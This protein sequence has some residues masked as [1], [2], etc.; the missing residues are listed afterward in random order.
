LKHHLGQLWLTIP[1]RELVAQFPAKQTNVGRKGWFDVAGGIGLQILKPYYKCSD[2]KLIDLLNENKKMQY[3]CGIDLKPGEYIRD[4]GVV[5]RWRGYLGRHLKEDVLQ[6]ILVGAWKPHMEQTHVNLSDAT[7]YESHVRYPTDVKLLWESIEWLWAQIRSIGK[8][9]KMPLPRVK[10][11][12]QK[13]KYQSYQRRRRKFKKEERRTRRRLLY[14]LDKLLGIIPVFIGGWKRSPHLV[15]NPVKRNFFQRLRTIK[16]VSQQQK[17]HF[18]RPKDSIPNRIVSLAKPYIRP[19]VRGKETKRVEFGM[20][21]HK[22]QIDG[23][24]FIEHW[25]FE[26]FHEGVRLKKTV[27]KHHRY[28]GKCHQFAGD[29][30]YA[31]NKNRKYCTSS[32]I[33]TC[34]KRK[35]RASKNEDQNQKLRQVLGKARATILEGSFGNEKN[36]YLLDKIKARNYHTER[37]WIFFGIFTPNAV[38]MSKR[39]HRPPPAKAC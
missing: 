10:Y 24:S 28:F 32:Q 20:K 30:I 6:Q 17:W 25:D 34:F 11:K 18:D 33:A 14:L 36:H 31:N 19:I 39:I 7:C 23:I 8:A 35:G 27:W 3:F 12:E 4:S 26:A 1:F 13:D 2:E 16:K 5:S 37:C 29:Q 21:L 22:M 15:I 9:I 38:K